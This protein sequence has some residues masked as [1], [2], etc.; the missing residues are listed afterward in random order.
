MSTFIFAVA[1]TVRQHGDTKFQAILRLS[2][3][4]NWFP[5]SAPSQRFIDCLRAEPEDARNDQGDNSRCEEHPDILSVLVQLLDVH[6]E[7]GGG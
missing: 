4:G 2:S 1:F 6:A 5:L 7:Y 3:V